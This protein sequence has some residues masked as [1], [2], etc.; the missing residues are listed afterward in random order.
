MLISVNLIFQPGWKSL[1]NASMD[2]GGVEPPLEIFCSRVIIGKYK[3]IYAE[4]DSR[5]QTAGRQEG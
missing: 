4:R 5:N 3:I 1:A 2:R